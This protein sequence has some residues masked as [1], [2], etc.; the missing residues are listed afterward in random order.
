MLGGGGLWES[1]Q[2]V[3]P[4]LAASAWNR[5]MEQMGRTAS[6]LDVVMKVLIILVGGDVGVGMYPNQA[7]VSFGVGLLLGV[8]LQ[9]ML[10]PRFGWRQNIAL[11]VIAFLLA[12][13]RPLFR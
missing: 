7:D 6:S 9:S 5:D 4:I 1:L 8:F 12:I 3:R 13:I 11:V 10:P 2:P